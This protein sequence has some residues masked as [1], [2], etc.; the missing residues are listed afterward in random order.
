MHDSGK[1][2][3][4]IITATADTTPTQI[5][6]FEDKYCDGEFA[7]RPRAHSGDFRFEASADGCGLT[8][9]VSGQRASV[10]PE[11]I[12]QMLIMLKRHNQWEPLRL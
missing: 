11:A 8:V 6:V 1:T 9:S 10:R 12:V 7:Y 5:R 3:E 2:R 4:W